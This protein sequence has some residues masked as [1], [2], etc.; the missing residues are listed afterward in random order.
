MNIQKCTQCTV[1]SSTQGECLKT[2]QGNAPE[3]L[4]RTELFFK[5]I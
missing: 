4:I 1:K 2:R 3:I 5:L